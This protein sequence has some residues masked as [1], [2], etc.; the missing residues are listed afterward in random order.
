MPGD[1]KGNMILLCLTH[2][3]IHRAHPKRYLEA[4]VD[5]YRTETPLNS[6]RVGA[7]PTTT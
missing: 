6:T 4:G 2:A 7:G 1:L 3:R 5:I